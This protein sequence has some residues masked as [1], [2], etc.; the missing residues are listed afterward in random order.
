[1]SNITLNVS[2]RTLRLIYSEMQGEY[3]AAEQAEQDAGERVKEAQYAHDEALARFNTV[4][5]DM[6]A[7]KAVLYPTVSVVVPSE[8]FGGVEYTV[9]YDK[10]TGKV[11]CTCPSFRFE[12]G[13]RNGACKHIRYA[14]NTR[15]LLTP[16]IYG[17][18]RG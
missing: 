18:L 3:E 8:T 14:I 13:L 17:G 15:G 5:Q 9:T 4:K 7:I 6:A 16:A 1:M 11:E 12:R 10:T 2:E